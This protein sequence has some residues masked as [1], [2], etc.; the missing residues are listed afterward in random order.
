[1]R[2][3]QFLKLFF[4]FFQHLP[5][6]K[7]GWRPVVGSSGLLYSSLGTAPL[8][9]PYKIPIQDYYQSTGRPV[10]TR[11]VAKLT[12]IAQAYRPTT[13]RTVPV[14]PAQNQPINSYLNPFALPSN[15]VSQYKFV[16]NYPVDNIFRNHHNPYLSRPVYQQKQQTKQ[17]LAQQYH[18]NI[19]QTLTSVQPIHFGQ[20]STPTPLDILGNSVQV[21]ARPDGKRPQ[22]GT[23]IY[24][25]EL[26]K[27]QD[28]DAASQSVTQQVKTAQQQAIGSLNIPNNPY[29][30]YSLQDLAGIQQLPSSLLGT[31]F[32]ISQNSCIF[33]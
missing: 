6:S 20:Y 4:F 19:L 33:M 29:F 7:S 3:C 10:A 22:S 2:I 21:Y 27:L 26:Y 1:M 14:S 9:A 18:N 25:Q 12:S 11:D 32:I 28:N 13:L 23:E 5:I 8:H 30:Q 17:K 24:K 31:C 15:G 16:Q